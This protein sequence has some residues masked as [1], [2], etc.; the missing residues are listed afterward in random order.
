M[1]AANTRVS[2]SVVLIFIALF[3]FTSGPGSAQSGTWQIKAPM[4]TARM[5][6]PSAV[7]DGKVYVATG[8][9]VDPVSQFPIRFT[10]LEIYDSITNSWSTGR[11]IPLGIYGAT[12]GAIG[13]KMYVAGGQAQSFS[14]ATLQIYDPVTDSWSTGAPMPAASGATAGG[15]I[16]GKL[17]VAGG[18]NAANTAAVS[19]LRIYDPITNTWTFGAPMPTARAAAT[20]GVIDGKLYVLGGILRQELEVYDPVTNTWSVKAPMPTARYGVGV[21]V[22][23]GILYAVGGSDNVNYL[24]IVEAYDPVSNAWTTLPAMPEGHYYPAVEVVGESM[25]VIGG[26]DLTG[27]QSHSTH[28]FRPAIVKKAPAIAVTGGTFPYDGNVHGATAA[29][30]GANGQAINGFLSVSYSPGGFAV[31]RDAGTYG[32]NVAFT[33][34]DPHYEDATLFVPAAV[35]INRAA[36]TI[37]VTGGTFTYNG[38]SWQATGS[39]SGV[40]GEQVFGTFNFTYTPG[41][42]QAPRTVG[43]YEVLGAF[44]PFGF[45][46]YTGGTGTA[47]IEV[48]PSIA[49]VSGPMSVTVE[50]TGPTGTP[51]FFNVNAFDFDGSLTPS[52]SRA[53]GS[54]FPLGTTPVTCTAQGANSSTGTLT[55]PVIVRDTQRPIIGNVSNVTAT[56][57]SSQGAVVSFPLPAVTDAGDPNPMVTASPASGSLFPHGT[58]TVTVTARDASNNTATKTFSINVTA[59]LVSISVSPSTATVSPGQGRQFTATGTFTDATTKILTS[60]SGGG[61]APNSG[62]GNHR[63]QAR[64]TP[65]LGIAACNPANP[66]PG[67]LSSQGFTPNASG[68]VD[69]QW[70]NGNPLHATGTA[71]PSQVTL[72]IECASG[73]AS[74]VALTATWTG[75][76]YEGSVVDFS[77]VHNTVA[78]TGWSSKAAMPAPR[79]GLGAATV[80][81]NGH[82]LVYVVGGATNGSPSSAL[83]AYDPATDTWTSLPPMPTP[84]EGAGVAAVN[85]RIYV[86]GGNVAGGASTNA[87]EVFDPIGGTWSAGTPLP[88]ARA[89]FSLVVAGG[90]LYAVG[91]DVTAN[92]TTTVTAALDRF[93]PA[94][95]AGW[96]SLAPMSSPRRSTAA[97][98]LN[99]GATIAVAGGA[100]SNG[101]ATNR[102]DLYN[103][104]T[105]QWTQGPNMLAPSAG[106]AGVVVS[107]ALHVFGGSNTG[108]LVLAELYRPSTNP[109]QPDG[110]A[111][112]SQMPTA[113]S[114]HAAAVVGDVVYV[115]GGQGSG[116]GAGLTTLEAFSILDPSQ[117][118]VSQGSSGGGS[119]LPAPTWRLSPAS[120]I[121]TINQNGFVSGN[122]PGQVTVIVEASGFSCET[123]NT[124]AT[125]IVRDTVAPLLSIPMDFTREATGPLTPVSFT[126]SAFDIVSGSVPV[127]CDHAPGSSFP[128]GTTTV[129]CSASDASGNTA[130]RSFTV[131]IVDTTAP[132]IA[133]VAP[134]NSLLGPP[135]HKMAPT[136][137]SVT[138]HDLVDPAPVC[139]V[140]GV[141]SSESEAHSG[142]GN[143]AVDWEFAAGSLEVLLRAER[144]GGGNG[145]IYTIRVTCSDASGNSADGFTTVTVR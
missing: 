76:R 25:F 100:A 45:S 68:T 87:V 37:L 52:C 65:G 89:H 62:P 26:Q 107:N 58:T 129:N 13:G 21:G 55:F 70:G 106:V 120:G 35:T 8:C 18:G 73:V 142:S 24:A 44:T 74:P 130:S 82:D 102:L 30:T 125:L 108:P 111:A 96:T 63:W 93:D 90:R 81:V 57:T 139:A 39:A 69:T 64:F 33:S 127:Q 137:L 78:I 88:A 80:T 2:T 38:F 141:L 17:Y 46:N 136:T 3:W 53:S 22:V 118:S 145:R 138:V 95:P 56:A 16:N 1:H 117:Y 112:L 99:N 50:A 121:A 54:V 126:V 41:G 36:P 9:C 86:A 131:T 66:A 20:A 110:W 132:D 32:V 43:A 7:I 28:E 12:S 51:A 85:G 6:M 49:N 97:G 47:T 19:T 40:Q 134:S 143:T 29:V 92:G 23:N 72:S 113:R 77:G 124:C 10:A 15:V 59:S 60:G 133:A 67:G 116:A 140:T 84:R 31:P 79:F 101:I 144:S 94:Q 115:M 14:V 103:V 114:Q 48:K 5:G 119:T 42:T 91:G 109:L 75:T 123:S 11:P 135:N 105:N 61:D 104:A 83:D 27:A 71:T 128:L 4:P 98:A 122:A 34:H